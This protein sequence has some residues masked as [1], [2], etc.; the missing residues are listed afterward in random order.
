MKHPIFVDMDDVI[1]ETTRTYP[2]LVKEEF[3]IEATYEGISNFDLCDSFGLTKAQLAHLFEVVHR[4]EILLG[5]APVKGARETLTWFQEKGHPIAIITGRPPKAKELSLEWLSS[6]Q[7]PFDT[8]EICDKYGRH[9]KNSS[10]SLDELKSRP[11]ALAV[12]D[13]ISMATFLSETMAVPTC[14]F[15]RPWN[16]RAPHSKAKRFT[17]WKSIRA[18]GEAIL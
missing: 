4:P 9:P 8:F 16:Q 13:S 12:E 5:F 14:L 6:N 17:S 1:A 7:I 3:G 10:I 2:K 18:F 11:F 15:D